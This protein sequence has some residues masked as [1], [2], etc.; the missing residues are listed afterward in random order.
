MSGREAMRFQ[1]ADGTEE[2]LDWVKVG[3]DQKDARSVLERRASQSF[4]RTV[5]SLPPCDR[6][7]DSEEV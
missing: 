6:E 7:G 3:H 4:Y 1:E 5:I 2:R